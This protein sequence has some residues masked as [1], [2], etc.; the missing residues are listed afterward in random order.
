M[1]YW[2]W[3][4]MLASLDGIPLS[5]LVLRLKSWLSATR[6]FCASWFRKSSEL[7]DF[8]QFDKS[9]RALANR[10]DWAVE[11]VG[12]C[13]WIALT[14][15]MTLTGRSRTYSVVLSRA[16]GT[17]PNL[18]SFNL[19]KVQPLGFVSNTQPASP[20]L[21]VQQLSFWSSAVGCHSLSTVNQVPLKGAILARMKWRIRR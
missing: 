12:P 1:V 8:I 7:D 15:K 3:F 19:I 2:A 20:G 17:Q 5:R 6:I 4:S 18:S 9:S 11:V 14:S 16:E 21:M 10:K 13:G